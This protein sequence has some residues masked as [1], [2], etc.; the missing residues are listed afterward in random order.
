MRPLK[1]TISGF[2]PYA[3]EEKIDFTKIGENGLFLI[4]GV[5]GAGKTTIF[6]AISYALYGECS[7]GKSRRSSNSY[8]SDYADLKTPTFV[9]FEFEHLGEKYYIKR[10]PGYV[11]AAKKGGGITAEDPAVTLK[12]GEKVLETKID[13]ANN[14][15]QEI[16]GLTRDQFA[17]TVMIAQGDFMKILTCSVNERKALFQKLFGTQ[18]YADLQKKLK[19]RNDENR[20]AFKNTKDDIVKSFTR[21]MV[22]EDFSGKQAMKGLI[23]DK[24]PEKIGQFT[25]LLD[26][27]NRFEDKKGRQLEGEK[28]ELD[29]QYTQAV[30]AFE[31]VKR[32]KQQFENLRSARKALL[33]LERKSEE[34]GLKRQEKEA[35][36]KALPVLVAETSLANATQ[37]TEDERKAETKYRD[38]L[39]QAEI[40]RKAAEDEENAAQEIVLGLEG[41]KARLV[42]MSRALE[43]LKERHEAHALFVEAAKKAAKSYSTLEEAE[44]K[45]NQAR[46][47]Y[48][49]NQYGA[50][51]EELIPGMACPVCGSLTHPAPA[52]RAEHAVTREEMEQ[53]EKEYEKANKA[54]HEVDAEKTKLEAR[55]TALV[56]SLSESGIDPESD[57]KSL[58]NEID[59]LQKTIT[60]ADNRL[61]RAQKDSREAEKLFTSAETKRKQC[62]ENILKYSQDQAEAQKSFQEVLLE[63]GF[64]DEAVYQSA[65]RSK[66]ELDALREEIS[67]Y[68]RNKDRAEQE[69]KRLENELSGKTEPDLQAFEQKVA[70]IQAELRENETRGKALAASSKVNQREA[71]EL[72][73]LD[74]ELETVREKYTISDE[75]YRNVSGQ[76]AGKVRLA[77]EVYVQQYFFNQVIIAANHRLNVL[78][79]GIY[80]LRCKQADNQRSQSGLELEVLDRMTGHWRDVNTLSGG[81]SFLAALSL[82][83]GLSDTVQ[84]GSGG[85]RLDSMF[86]DE[87]FGSLDEASLQQALKLLNELAEGKRLIGIISHV[88]ALEGRIEKKIL[89]KKGQNGAYIETE[90]I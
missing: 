75:L 37:R 40:K 33:E 12:C 47:D 87:G 85:I 26:E 77:F 81:E 20:N 72:R 79:D 25:K 80:A 38:Q 19:D 36:E 2:G 27:L 5:T 51:A 73:R 67:A 31:K 57:T 35:A 78:T 89:V 11:R 32:E 14:R 82:A 17:Q 86:I 22:P 60:D 23:V 58:R 45:K 39:A 10:N 8:R 43:T 24:V 16:V 69:T 65:K 52:K 90:G 46:A 1:L 6:D 15:I 83:L 49:A 30:A 68:D 54:W 70:E 56:R 7:G 62:T 34:I 71:V 44:A 76:V 28:K 84:A 13:T 50:I 64:T 63:N 66:E 59:L 61:R 48:F 21:V 53:T 18:I 88:A 3:G 4:T 74:R 29:Q 41:D 42:N 9:E 55:D